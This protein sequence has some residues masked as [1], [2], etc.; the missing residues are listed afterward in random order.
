VVFEERVE[1]GLTRFAA[2]YHSQ[3]PELVGPVRSAR[4]AD[5]DLL[6]PFDPLVVISGAAPGPI[7]RLHDAGLR[8][9]QENDVPGFVRTAALPPYNLFVRPPDL[10]PAGRGLRVPS[11]P[12]TVAAGAPV[13]GTALPRLAMAFSSVASATWDWD[14]DERAWLR[15]QDGAPHVLSDETRVASENV[16]VAIGAPAAT[17]GDGV[18]LRDGRGYAM[19]WRKAAADLHFEWLTPSGAVMPLAPGR[20]WVELLPAGATLSG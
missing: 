15:S 4:D 8:V 7:A 20:T 17:E 9:V 10:L 6:L 2:L 16:V 1:G 11:T 5:A 19:R 3:I 14:P 13:G 18:L 12:W